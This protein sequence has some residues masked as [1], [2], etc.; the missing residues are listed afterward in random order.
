MLTEQKSWQIAPQTMVDSVLIVDDTPANIGVLRELL[1]PQNYQLYIA[2]SGEQAL[3]TAAAVPL[4]LILL[5]V[6]MP[7]LDGFETCK[8]LKADKATCEIPVIFVTARSD[9]QDV[10][11]GFAIG[12]VDYI[13]KPVRVEEVLARVRTQLQIRRHLFEQRVQA[14]R[15][16]AIVNNMAEGLLVMDRRGRILSSNPAAEHL[17]GYQ[18]DDLVGLGM[19]DFLEAELRPAYL[20]YFANTRNSSAPPGS[21]Q[22]GS[23]EVRL[24]H[25]DGEWR[26]LDLAVTPMFLAEPLFV[27]L[28]HDVSHYKLKHEAL[29]QAAQ[30]DALTNVANRRHFDAQ[31]A[32]RWAQAVLDGS[33][34]IVYLVDVDFFKHYNDLAGHQAG[35]RCLQAVARCLQAVADQHGALLAR[36]GGEEF[37]LMLSGA[38]ALDAQALAEALCEQV[39]QARLPHPAADWPWVSVSVGYASACPKQGQSAEATLLA[40]DQAMYRAK[41]MGRDRACGG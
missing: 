40:S 22:H 41:A 25:S 1:A 35:D 21:L 29:A 18:P 2:T 31:L 14:E 5:D 11:A 20:D 10:V 4:D 19:V 38:N 24:K 32:E 3:A 6:T 12:A 33:S 13:N 30:V 23:R 15:L 9:T 28:L 16:R 39:R 37:V 27:G 8:R 17:L 7:G 26:V 36:Y 34:F